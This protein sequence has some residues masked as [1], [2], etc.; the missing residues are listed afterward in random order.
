VTGRLRYQVLNQ[1]IAERLALQEAIKAKMSISKDEIAAAEAAARSA[2]GLDEKAF[3][4][5]IQ[6]QYGSS[7]AFRHAVERDLIIKKF[8]SEKIVAAGADPVTARAAVSTWLQK[9]QGKSTIR[10]AL[11][12]NGSTAGCGNNCNMAGG[13]Q[14]QKQPAS[15][16]PCCKT[17]GPAA[18]RHNGE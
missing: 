17:T 14:Q 12:E 16:G 5:E 15:A 2:S 1:M 10:I 13:Q 6:S 4:K 3:E 8:I 18:S 7:A 11:A 9:V